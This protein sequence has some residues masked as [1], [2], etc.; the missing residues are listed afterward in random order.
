MSGKCTELML[1]NKI[2]R[3]MNLGT[4]CHV[5]VPL[6]NNKVHN[7]EYSLKL[8][9]LSRKMLLQHEIAVMFVRHVSL[10]EKLFF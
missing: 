5:T 7:N 1:A 10:H 8:V 4:Q 2:F 9:R 3:S 6:L